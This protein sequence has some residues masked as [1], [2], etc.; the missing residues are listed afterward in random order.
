MLTATPRHRIPPGR[1]GESDGRNKK[2]ILDS[3]QARLYC[4]WSDLNP[5]WS[6]GGY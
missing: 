6:H 2:Y 1:I 5:F 3:I 4:R